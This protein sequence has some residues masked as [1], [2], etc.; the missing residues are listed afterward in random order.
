MSGQIYNRYQKLKEASGG[1][2]VFF[3]AE[4]RRY[5]FPDRKIPET[6]EWAKTLNPHVYL[7]LE[8][9]V[10]HLFLLSFLQFD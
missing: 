6:P 7:L 3:S 10:H 5:E 2:E 1:M 9:E 8:C 4:M